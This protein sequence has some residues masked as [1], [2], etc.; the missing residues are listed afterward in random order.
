MAPAAASK[1]GAFDLSTV[2]VADK[3][4]S[5]EAATALAAAAKKEGVQFFEQI[6]FNAAAVAV[7]LCRLIALSDD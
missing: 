5:T 3:A 6:G 2:F 7:S 4:A 1:A